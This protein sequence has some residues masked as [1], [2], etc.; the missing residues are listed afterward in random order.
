MCLHSKAWETYILK[1]IATMEYALGINDNRILNLLIETNASYMTRVHTLL[2]RYTHRKKITYTQNRLRVTSMVWMW[3]Q[4]FGPKLSIF[5]AVGP[6]ISV[7]MCTTHLSNISHCYATVS[8]CPCS[9]YSFNVSVSDL[10][11]V[12][13]T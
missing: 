11:L 3:Y 7:I 9:T 6:H 13:Q 8:T 5:S 4:A 10:M 1:V 12:F 2:L